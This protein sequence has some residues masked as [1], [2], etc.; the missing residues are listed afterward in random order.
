MQ[1]R[2]ATAVAEMVAATCAGV[3]VRASRVI[4][5]FSTMIADNAV[6]TS[7]RGFLTLFTRKNRENSDCEEMSLVPVSDT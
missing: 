3:M 5:I 2:G 4:G 1:P 7:E 6:I